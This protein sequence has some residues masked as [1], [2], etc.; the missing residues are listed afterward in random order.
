MYNYTLTNRDGKQYSVQSENKLTEEELTEISLPLNEARASDYFK[1]AASAIAD[2]GYNTLEFAHEIGHFLGSEMG[3]LLYGE[4]ASPVSDN[5]WTE[6]KETSREF[7]EGDIPESVKQKLSYKVVAKGLPQLGV[8]AATAPL[9]PFTLSAQGFAAGRDD[10]FASMGIDPNTATG[11]E[12]EQGRAVGA[13]VAIPTVVLERIGLGKI[14]QNITKKIDPKQ[15]APAFKRVVSSA[16]MEGS[17]E[18]LEQ[19]SQNVVAKDIAQYDPERKRSE[20]MGEAALVGSLVAG[21][22]SA[23]RYS[24]RLITESVAGVQNVSDLV[25]DKAELI[26]QSNAAQKIIDSTAKGLIHSSDV[27]SDLGQRAVGALATKGINVKPLVEGGQFVAE[28]TKMGTKNIVEASKKPLELVQKGVDVYRK[29]EAARMV[30]DFIRPLNDRVRAYNERIGQTLVS[31]EHEHMKRYHDFY[32][33]AQAPLEILDKIEKTS[34]DDANILHKAIL[35][36]DFETAKQVFLKHGTEVEWQDIGLTIRKI[37]EESAKRGSGVGHIEEYFPRFIKDFK[38]LGKKLGYDIPNSLWEKTVQNAENKKGEELTSEELA[39][40]FE[41]LIRSKEFRTAEAGKPSFLKGRKIDEVTDELSEFYASPL[42]AMTLYLN[43]MADNITRMDYLGAMYD[44]VQ[45]GQEDAIYT[46]E[47][48]SEGGGKPAKKTRR[49]GEF[50][51][52]I[53]EEIEAGRLDDTQVTEIHRLLGARFQKKTPMHGFVRGAKTLTHLL[54]LGSPT[55]A[56]TQLGDYAYSFYRNGINE[57]F[58]ALGK[59]EWTLEDVY[60]IGNDI[61][62]EF[63][64]KAEV[65]KNLQKMLDRV[66]TLTG[67]RAMDSKAKATFL[68]GTANKWKKIL[69]GRDSKAKSDLIQ[70]IQK[71]Q[72]FQQ[73]SE[74]IAALRAGKKTEG[75]AEMLLYELGDIAPITQSDMPLMYNKNPNIRMLYALKSYTL[76]QF[77]LARKD[78]F[79]KLASGDRAEVKEGFKNLLA[80]SSSLALANIPADVIKAFITGS[81]FDLDDLHIDALWRIFGLN[82]YTQTMIQRDG[83]GSALENLTY[84]L[85]LVQVA[86]D[87]GRDV[88]NFAPPLISKDSRTTKYIP[89]IGK[90]LHSWQKD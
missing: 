1:G 2:F 40:L 15:V 77:N 8:M 10:Y 68:T 89:V 23:V 55:T 88:L 51:R 20:G 5:P 7:Y 21:T 76:K 38:G 12:L 31:F 67:M 44:V 85:P 64:E 33:M 61:G 59:P 3:E 63:T 39:A 57:T 41:D 71:Q 48:I 75:V 66:L 35:R 72:G 17:T 25:V 36:K 14:A 80:L 56:I 53:Q 73:A 6:L 27:A 70:R 46:P 62:F 90:L 45:A 86:D 47:E 4:K 30:D 79:A 83:V 82:S 52:A 19:L 37:Y 24:P 50:G 60:Q 78:I 22:P 58:R 43:Q 13:M 18:A 28:K 49:L 26:A 29:S 84:K 87:L 32:R 11:E 42:E 16:A 54:F 34:K 65:P 74:T 69:N 81:E 9:S